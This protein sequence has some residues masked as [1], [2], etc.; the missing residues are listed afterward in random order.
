MIDCK[1][2]RARLRKEETMQYYPFPEQKRWQY[3]FAAFLLF[4]LAL[5]RSGM[6]A[7]LIGFLPAQLLMLGL[8]A[9]MG[10]L[11]LW[12]R[13]KELP[14]VL[15]DRRIVAAA[16]VSLVLLLPMLVKQDWQLMYATILMGLLLAVLM[17]YFVTLE[18]TAKW[19]VLLLCGLSVYSVFAT[20][21]LRRLP[22]AGILN[23]PRFVNAAGW[24]Y[25]FFGLA[26]VSI[27]HVAIRNFGIF[28][29]PGVHQ[30]FLLVGLYLTNYAIPWKRERHMWIAA[31]ILAVTLITTMATGGVVALGLYI[32][33]VFFDKKLYRRKAVLLLAIGA[34]IAAAAVLIWSFRVQNGI[35]WF[36]YDTLFEKFINR[37][38]SVTERAEGIAWNLSLFVQHPLFGARLA[39]VLHGVANNTSSTLIM[40]AGFGI[41]G[42][43]LHIVGWIALVWKRERNPITNLGLLAVLFMAF[44]TQNLTW[45]LYFWLFPTMALLEK[46][47]PRLPRQNRELS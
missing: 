23:V 18:Q 7:T 24:E 31:A 19:Y 38:D 11:F 15:T 47:L 8:I 20:Y 28:R 30:F 27:E 44:N 33:V 37:S 39:E 22:D 2:G 5:T 14:N 25:Y 36:V 41:P 35:Y 17:S 40:L 46:L 26:S 10:L 42:C 21:V 1:P 34:V 4:Q 43:L 32:V 16:V 29:E 6:A 12:H 13:R 45:D 9:A 3:L